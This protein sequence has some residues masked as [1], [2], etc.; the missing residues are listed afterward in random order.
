[1]ETKSFFFYAHLLDQYTDGEI[2]QHASAQ[3]LI[4]SSTNLITRAHFSDTNLQIQAKL[5][6]G[7]D[8]RE[9]IVPNHRLMM[10]LVEWLSLVIEYEDGDPSSYEYD[11]EKF[12]RDLLPQMVVV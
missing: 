12:K 11:R 9:F 3:E 2:I 4:V 1:M 5:R 8:Y 6:I 7:D 10:E